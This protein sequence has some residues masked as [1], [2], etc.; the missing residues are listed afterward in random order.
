MTDRPSLARSTAKSASGYDRVLALLRDEVTSGRLKTGDRLLPEREIATVL[1]VSRPVVREALRAL[2]ALGAVEIRRGHG[3]L[4]KRPDLSKLADYFTYVLAQ[5]P[6]VVADVMEA[7]IAI[8]RQATRLA[9]RRASQA[10]FEKFELALQRI[11]A[12]IGQPVLGGRADFDF[13]SC[14]VAAAH[15][16]TLSKLYTAISDLLRKSHFDRRKKI[17]NV[18]GIH[19]FLVNH[20][21]KL[22]KVL[23]D[24][25]VDLADKLLLEHFEIGAEFGRIANLNDAN[26]LIHREKDDQKSSLVDSDR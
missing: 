4:V 5:E 8:E 24:R 21:I 17:L 22:F 3:T 2:E 23:L 1:G 13:H 16:P 25:D 19:D 15:S 10:D 20:H 7:R 9:C 18:D 11:V 6:D 14:L 26:L 12:T